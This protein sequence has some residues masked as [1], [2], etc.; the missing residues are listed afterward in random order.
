M[1]ELN[2]PPQRQR[3]LDYLSGLSDG[4]W[5]DREQ[6]AVALGTTKRAAGNL[7]T[8]LLEDGLVTC[9]R[10]TDEEQRADIGVRDGGD[11]AWRAK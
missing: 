2:L 3:A 10:R 5:A 6:V 11:Y 1:R 4:R 7:L 9:R 8:R